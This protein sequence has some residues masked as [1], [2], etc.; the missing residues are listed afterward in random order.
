M[1]LLRWSLLSS[2]IPKPPYETN[3]STDC[4]TPEYVA[5]VRRASGSNPSQRENAGFMGSIHGGSQKRL[6]ASALSTM[7]GTDSRKSGRIN[8]H[9]LQTKESDQNAVDFFGDSITEYWDTAAAF[10]ELKTA[11]RSIADDTTRVMLFR[12]PEDVIDLHPRLVI[13]LGGINDLYQVAG[14]GTPKSVASNVRSILK[15]IHESL[16]QTPVIAC[17]ILPSNTLGTVN[18]ANAAVDH[19]VADFPQAHRLKLNSLY[20]TPDG[21]QNASL[22]ID[23]THPNQAGY[24]VWRSALSVTF[25]SGYPRQQVARRLRQNNVSVQYGVL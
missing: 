10:P 4:P 21:H 20:L 25:P 11:N 16:S 8:R 5:V 19:V 22:F 24:A 14:G 18:W 3:H 13:F 12:L 6:P 23:G 15:V 1:I 9:N 17:E 7:S 2:N